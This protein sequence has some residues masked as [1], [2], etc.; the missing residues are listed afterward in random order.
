MKKLFALTLLLGFSLF[1]FASPK[2]QSISEKSKVEKSVKE[3]LSTIEIDRAEPASLNVF[4]FQHESRIFCQEKAFQDFN[5]VVDD[6]EQCVGWPF[7]LTGHIK[8]SSKPPVNYITNLG[9]KSK[10]NRHK[11]YG[12]KLLRLRQ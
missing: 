10:E 5:F 1:A 12:F 7:P 11:G 4:A 9:S 3:N 6:E 8:L 2:E